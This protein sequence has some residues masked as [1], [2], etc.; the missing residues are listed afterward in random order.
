LFRLSAR[1]ILSR[2]RSTP[3]ALLPFLAQLV[4]CGPYIH[5]VNEQHRK[6]V[7][8]RL[9]LIKNVGAA[10]AK[11]PPLDSAIPT[12]AKLSLTLH[13][14]PRPTD[15]ATIIYAEDFRNLDELGLV[16]NRMPQATLV[17]E[18]S[19]ALHT[20]R[21]PWNP[22][23]HASVPGGFS[24]Y[25]ARGIYPVCA[26]LEYL[27]VIRTRAFAPVSVDAPT[28]N[29]GDAAASKPGASSPSQSFLGGYLDAEVLI[30]EL[31]SA[32]L[33]GGFGFEAE[34]SSTQKA[35]RS[36]G[37]ARHALE[38]DFARRVLAA[39]EEGLAKHAPQSDFSTGGK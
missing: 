27:V 21:H 20:E 33:V 37:A 1:A 22:L 35:Q 8:A 9:A 3:I 25:R 32:R 19:A 36:A 6:A 18:C 31:G 39:L 5:E 17:S 10:L 34:S 4:G 15:N 26:K 7:E 30:F 12:S 14:F 16:R 29:P 28:A 2:M 11:A 24:G 13:H 23:A 38:A